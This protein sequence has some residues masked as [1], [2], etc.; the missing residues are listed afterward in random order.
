MRQD[1]RFASRQRACAPDVERQRPSNQRA[2]RRL[3]NDAREQASRLV[4]GDLAQRQPGGDGHRHQ[5]RR[6]G[7]AGRGRG[8]GALGVHPVFSLSLFREEASKFQAIRH[9]SALLDAPLPGL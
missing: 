2:A 7:Q 6:P 8:D 1:R 5:Q 9:G 3:K 4:A